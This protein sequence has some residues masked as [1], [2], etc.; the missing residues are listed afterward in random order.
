MGDPRKPFQ[1]RNLLQWSAW[2]WRYH[3]RYWAQTLPPVSN[4][5]NCHRHGSSS[6]RHLSTRCLTLWRSLT[7]PADVRSTIV[8]H[9]KLV[10]MNHCGNW[11]R[12]Y[13]I[14]EFGIPSVIV[15]ATDGRNVRYSDVLLCS[16]GPG[17]NSFSIRNWLR[18]SLWWQSK[19]QFSGLS[20]LTHLDTVI[21]LAASEEFIVSSIEGQC[22]LLRH[23]RNLWGLWTHDIHGVCL[24]PLLAE[25]YHHPDS[26]HFPGY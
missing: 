25:C 21:D 13:G 6:G 17:N 2:E 3:G 5:T 15:Q 12:G 18:S 9:G 10:P 1:I 26:S 19:G 20:L 24:S 11:W 16:Q 4:Q 14:S 22:F 8:E 23:F 7:H